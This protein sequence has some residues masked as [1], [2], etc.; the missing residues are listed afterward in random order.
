MQLQRARPPFKVSYKKQVKRAHCGQ[1][2]P[3][4][5][6]SACLVAINFTLITNVTEQRTL[7][8]F[9]YILDYACGG[10]FGLDER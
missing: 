8:S 2:A 7:V 3:S 10:Y 1:V 9:S 6:I 5:G 4:S